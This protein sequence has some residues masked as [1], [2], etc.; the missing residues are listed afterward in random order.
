MN[1]LLT[2]LNQ[3]FPP[4][5]FSNPVNALCHDKQ[6]IA[7]EK[8]CRDFSFFLLK[9]SWLLPPPFIFFTYEFN[10]SLNAILINVKN[11]VLLSFCTHKTSTKIT[12]LYL[13]DRGDHLVLA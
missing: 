1:N 10:Y 13:L 4:K 11:V 9:G 7:L 8:T 6:P 3:N 5:Q 2:F 12:Q